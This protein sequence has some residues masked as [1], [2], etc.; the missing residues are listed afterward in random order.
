MK[1]E[2]KND[3]GFCKKQMAFEFVSSS[4]GKAAVAKAANVLFKKYYLD[5]DT[6]KPFFTEAYLSDALKNLG[7]SCLCASLIL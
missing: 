2:S 5:G 1:E 6:E 3:S 7:L 4:D